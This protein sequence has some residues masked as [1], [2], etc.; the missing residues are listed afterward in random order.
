MKTLG[1]CPKPCPRNFL[2]EVPWGLS[3]TLN[4]LDAVLRVRI[5][6]REE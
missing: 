5:L 3:R 1:R 4:E 2:E 6:G